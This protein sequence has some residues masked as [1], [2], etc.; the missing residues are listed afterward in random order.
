MLTLTGE[1]LP[2]DLGGWEDTGVVI[3]T[4]VFCES[5]LEP[6]VARLDLV[7]WCTPGAAAELLEEVPETLET[8]FFDD[9]GL[10]CTLL[11]SEAF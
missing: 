10:S 7:S 5:A 8:V 2:V 9:L 4:R 1:E 6:C 3:D 11:F